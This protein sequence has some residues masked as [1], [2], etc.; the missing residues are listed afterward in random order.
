MP[1][2]PWPLPNPGPSSGSFDLSAPQSS[3]L[4]IVWEKG[5]VPCAGWH[6]MRDWEPAQAC[7]L[8][9][10]ALQRFTRPSENKTLAQRHQQTGAGSDPA[11]F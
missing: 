9:P 6:P 7:G 2:D 8:R 3:E 5:L 1:A 11:D 4:S 10:P